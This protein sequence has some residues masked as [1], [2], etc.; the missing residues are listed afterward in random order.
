MHVEYC[1]KPRVM[2]YIRCA[3]M[4]RFSIPL[5][6][7]WL[8]YLQAMN[9]LVSQAGTM[10]THGLPNDILYNF[11]LIIE[12][13][14]IQV[15]RTIVYPL[16]RKWHIKVRYLRRTMASKTDLISLAWTNTSYNLRL[17]CRCPGYGLGSN[18]A[19]YRVFSRAMLRVSAHV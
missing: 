14:I 2:W 12:I 7:A 8:C 5:P 19:A 15:L 4:Q 13:V 16:L 3:L 6:I 17:C 9:N 10:E 11:Q 1:E 18:C